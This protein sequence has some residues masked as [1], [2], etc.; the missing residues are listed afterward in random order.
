[1]HLHDSILWAIG[2]EGVSGVD[3]FCETSKSQ[4][5]VEEFEEI[6]VVCWNE[7]EDAV[8]AE[9]GDCTEKEEECDVPAEVD[10]TDFGVRMLCGPLYF[11]YRSGDEIDFNG[12]AEKALKRALRILLEK[13]PEISYE[14]YI[15]YRW[16]NIH[17]GDVTQYELSSGGENLQETDKTYSFVGEA[18][19]SKIQEEE[20]WEELTEQLDAAECDDFKQVLNNFYAYRKW[21]SKED[22]ERILEVADEINEDFRSEL[23]ELLKVW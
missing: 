13:Y 23:E 8:E 6:F 5:V 22:A 14:G 18:L 21:I 15:G 19:A 11:S 3:I 2:P 1:M 4:E 17:C 10:V 12:H 7:A 9:Y 20:F 16:S